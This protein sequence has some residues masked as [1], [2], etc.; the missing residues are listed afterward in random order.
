MYGLIAQTMQLQI[1]IQSALLGLARN[2][3]ARLAGKVSFDVEW[4]EDTMAAMTKTLVP[5][6]L[7]LAA[8][9]ISMTFCLEA[10]TQSPAPEKNVSSPADANARKAAEL[11][12]EAYRLQNGKRYL[13]ALTKIAEAEALAPS[14]PEVYN[15]RGSIYLSAQMRDIEKA[16]IEFKK[17]HEL[18]PEALPPR[19]NLAELE[20][21]AG[22]FSEA[23]RAFRGLLQKFDQ[24]PQAMRHMVQFKILVCLVKQ[25]KLA[26]AESEL[27][28]NFD[29]LDETPAYY[30]SQGV[31]ALAK[32]EERKGNEW[33]AKAQIIYK[34]PENLP[35]LDSL[36]ETG[37]IHSVDLPAASNPEAKP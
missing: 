16:R 26:E 25:K 28:A 19:F 22:S 24:L 23:E 34:K 4:V 13:D 10:Q 36:M 32:G 27:K 1:V 20:F 31:L 30:F 37:Y 9:M 8:V 3:Y 33:L 29:F 2:S 7:L 5:H 21:V 18:Q 12:Q 17:C 6:S 11:L 14:N 15:L 35:Y